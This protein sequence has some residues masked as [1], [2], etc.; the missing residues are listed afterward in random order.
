MDGTRGG[1][2]R[3]VY[4]RV[5]IDPDDIH[6]AIETLSDGT[7]SARDGSD[8]DGMIP[9]EGECKT[10]FFCMG[11]DLRGEF[12]C[13]GGYRE[14]VVHIELGG[15]LFGEDVFVGVDGVVVVDGVTEGIPEIIKETGFD[16]EVGSYIN[17]RFTLG[18]DLVRMKRLW[19]G[20]RLQWEGRTCPPEKPTET[21]PSWSP[22]GR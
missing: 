12:L 21:R 17:T 2:L 10:T 16:E 13:D 5:G 18:E 20:E 19:E 1:C 22:E 8:G 4:V 14:G 7:G 9:T 3:G 15:V 6:A 11:V